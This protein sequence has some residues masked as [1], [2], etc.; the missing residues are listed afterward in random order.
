M[1]GRKVNYLLAALTGACMV[2]IFPGWNWTLLAP[3]TVTPLLLASAAESNNKQRFALGYL[4][5]FLYACGVYYWFAGVLSV[6]GGMGDWGGFGTYLVYCFLRAIHYGLFSLG[7]AQL[8]Q[9]RWAVLLI[10]ALWTGL[11]R[12]QHPLSNFA[13]TLLGNAATDMSL[14]M[15]LAPWV[16]VY[17]LSFLLAMV[18]TV[19]ALA[20]LGRPRL[21]LAPGLLVCGLFFLPEL[22]A[23][24]NALSSAVS[25]QPNIDPERVSWNAQTVA[26]LETRMGGLSLE[27][28]LAKGVARPSMILWPELPA[29][30]YY[31]ED[32]ALRETITRVAR[33]TQTP[34]VISSVSR[35]SSGEGLNVAQFIDA[36]GNPAGNYA[37][38]YLVPFGEYVPPL[39]SW[40]NKISNEAGTFAPG[41]AINDFAIGDKRAGV[42]ICYESAVPHH[43]RLFAQGGAQV[44]V[45]LT[46]DGYFFRTAARE[47][48]LLLGRMRAAENGRWL[49]RSS[50]NGHTVSIDPA[51]RIV[52]QFP[53]FVETADRLPFN[54]VSAQTFYTMHGD[55]FAWGCLAAACVMIGWKATGN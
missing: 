51:G 6:H 52:K 28:A 24:E 35:N 31:E 10:P 27:S 14:P 19:V 54:W 36:L 32:V 44:L 9:S 39:F 12:T 4:S 20:L 22:P 7:A 25:V 55:W 2:V 1:S 43:V 21:E 3:L 42:F 45:M 8:L 46:N 33:A 37:K 13:W 30:I 11:E 41:T 48:H 47:Q 16:G 23:P 34:L 5:G 15:R 50:N 40:V 26:N 29:P 53:Q 17:G 38:N 49:L 18:G